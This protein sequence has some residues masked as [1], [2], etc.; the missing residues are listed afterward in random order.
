MTIIIDFLFICMHHG[1][2]NDLDNKDERS[3]KAISLGVSARLFSLRPLQYCM[4][5]ENYFQLLQPRM[6]VKGADAK[7]RCARYIANTSTLRW[8]T[9]IIQNKFRH[10]SNTFDF[11][12]FETMC[13]ICVHARV[14]HGYPIRRL[15]VPVPETADRS[16]YW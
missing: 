10:T 2:D 7:G 3:N 13:R 16:G 5:A 1:G 12:S 11:F 9:H 15:P 14:M 6:C 4:S 8:Q